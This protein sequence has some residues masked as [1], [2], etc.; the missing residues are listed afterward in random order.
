RKGLELVC[1][2]RP[3]VPDALI[4]D[5]G[6]LRQVL[7]NLVGNAIKFTERGEVVL[8]VENAAEPAP[9][10]EV[11]LRFAVTDTGIGIPP[12]KQARIFQAF[13]QEDT[14]TTRKY[15]G[16]GLGLTIAARLV[17]LMGGGIT[18][19][20]VPGQGSTFAFMA[21]FEL[22]PHPSETTAASPPVVLRDLPVLIV[23]DNAT[24]RRILEEWLRGYSMEPT[25]AGDGVTAMDALWHGVAQGRPYPLVLLDGRMP[26]IDGLALAAK[27]RQRAEL[28]A[29]RIILLTSGDRPG[30]QTRARQLGISATLHKP[31]Q[32]CEM[33]ETILRVMSHQGGPEGLPVSP[34][35][36]RPPIP[37]GLV[38]VPLRI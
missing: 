30:D 8:L 17:A 9:E 12:E 25:A 10:G 28:S 27:I 26:D 11:G 29:T 2:Q 37:E 13:E 21:R 36:V 24:N 5:A 20:S 33:L 35:V 34:A 4:G 6:R 31:L 7:L 15:G 38:G 1:Q 16:T 3:D 23:D 18:V 32:Q 19:D 14:S 22:Q